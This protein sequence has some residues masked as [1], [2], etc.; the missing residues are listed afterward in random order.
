MPVSKNKRRNT[1][2]VAKARFTT[3]KDQA[4][5]NGMKK[6]YALLSRATNGVVTVP[7]L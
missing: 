3:E 6:I 5:T 2:K 1:G 7:L 4:I